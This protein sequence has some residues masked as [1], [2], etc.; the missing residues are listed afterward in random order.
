[1][2]RR[3]AATLAVVALLGLAGCSALPMFEEP[4]PT[5]TAT[6]SP[7]AHGTPTPTTTVDPD[8]YP[9]G[10]GPSG[11]VAPDVAA[12]NHERTLAGY[13]S[14]RFRFDVGVG[15]GNGTR[16]AFVYLLRVDHGA[17][18]VLEIR[19]DGEVTRHQYLEED[20]LYVMLEVDGEESYNSTD[21]EYVPE[22]F[23]G[24]QFVAPLFEHVE[25]GPPDVLETENGTIYRYRSRRVTDPNVI[26]PA[27][28]TADEIASFEVELLVHE[29]GYVRGARYAVVTEEGSELG[30]IATIDG[31]N[32]T[33]VDRPDWYDRATDG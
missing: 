7:T 12:A 24:I 31:V 11:L 8:E 6:P 15:A 9:D 30:A 3:V 5:T 14:Y 13:E 17:K 18:R 16:D 10:Y 21:A 20:R 4:S 32:A 29:D 19:D 1:M 27:N 23:S 2:N 33:A 22:Q 28:V 26:L 25:Y